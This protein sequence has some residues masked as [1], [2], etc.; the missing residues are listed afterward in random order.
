MLLKRPDYIEDGPD[1][2]YMTHVL[3]PGLESALTKARA[4]ACKLDDPDNDY[5]IDPKDYVC[6]CLIKGKVMD[7][8]PER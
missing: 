2:T 6:L 3:T 8:N 7:L 5:P 4:E 1:D